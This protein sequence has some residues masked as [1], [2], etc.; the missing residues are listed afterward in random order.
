VI[1]TVVVLDRRFPGVVARV[2]LASGRVIDLT[3]ERVEDAVQARVLL[4]GGE[5]ARARLRLSP[6]VRFASLVGARGAPPQWAAFAEKDPL[7]ER[8]FLNAATLDLLR[9]V[10]SAKD[11]A[12]AITTVGPRH[13][14]PAARGLE[15]LGPVVAAALEKGILRV[16][17]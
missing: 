3:A 5:L 14:V 6:G 17:R 4:A 11:V 1:Q 12:T 7:V 8:T 13:G 10:A 16:D 9:A 15:L 2:P